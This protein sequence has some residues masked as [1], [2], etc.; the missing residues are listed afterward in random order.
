MAALT[1]SDRTR[2][3][4]NVSNNLAD[5]TNHADVDALKHVVTQGKE[6]IA[7]TFVPLP[8]KPPYAVIT[9]G[10]VALERPANYRRDR[11]TVIVHLV[12]QVLTDS[13]HFATLIGTAAIDGIDTLQQAVLT[14]LERSRPYNDGTHITGAAFAGYVTQA[15]VIN[16]LGIELGEPD[17]VVIDR[18]PGIYLKSEL[19]LEY[20]VITGTP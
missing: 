14:A 19:T 9:M 6:Q 12:H 10:R 11:P 3:L 13:K 20:Q 15:N 1:K 7:A 18:F 16:C 8:R 2:L 17:L 4:L 5:T